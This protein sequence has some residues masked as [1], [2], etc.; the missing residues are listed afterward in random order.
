MKTSYTLIVGVST[1][2]DEKM[3]FSRIDSIRTYPS[4][5]SAEEAGEAALMAGA[6]SWCIPETFEGEI[7]FY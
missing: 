1:T 4:L 7:G 5:D 2:D 3:R 6:D